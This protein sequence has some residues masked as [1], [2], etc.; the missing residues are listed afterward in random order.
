MKVIDAGAVGECSKHFFGC[1]L[2]LAVLVFLVRHPQCCSAPLAHLNAS[3]IA[4]HA[5]FERGCAWLYGAGNSDRIQRSHHGAMQL[6]AVCHG[7][8]KLS[9]QRFCAA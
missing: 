7:E 1:L 3:A 6:L 4:L 9:L 8:I 2:G 5:R